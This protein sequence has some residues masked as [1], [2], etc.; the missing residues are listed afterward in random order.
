MYSAHEERNFNFKRG[1]VKFLLQ[2]YLT[3]IL[4]SAKNNLAKKQAT[5]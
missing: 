5:C 1:N 4:F 2:N 3:I